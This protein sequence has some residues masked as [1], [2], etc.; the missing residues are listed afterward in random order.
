MACDR[1]LVRTQGT[2]GAA[3]PVMIGPGGAGGIEDPTM[4]EK[5]TSAVRSSFRAW[6]ESHGRPPALAEAMVDDEVGVK[7]VTWD[8]VKRLLTQNEY[9]DAL[10]DGAE[11]SDVRTVVERG[12]LATF[13]GT[14]AVEFGLADAIADTL[15]EVLED[16]RAGGTTLLER[17]RSEELSALLHSLRF[18]LL[19]GGLV[20]AYL[21]LKMPGFGIPGILSITCFA[22]FLFGQYTVGL[23]D[24][25]HIVMVGAGLALLAVE[26]FLAPGTL[27]FGIAGALL[28]VSGVVLTI[29]G[30]TW[31]LDYA[32]DRRIAFDAI[33]ALALWSTAAVFI[34]W[35]LARM[36]PYTPGVSWMVLKPSGGPAT[37]EGVAETRT[38][39][40]KHAMI[41]A[42]G[43]AIT[44]L[45]PVGRI[46]LD[47]EPGEDFEARTL[48]TAL[49]SGARVRVIE[50]QSGRL[51]VEREVKA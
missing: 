40:E 32:L 49:D 16:M 17:A 50:V 3:A 35:G 48:G 37:G 26:I 33:F 34:A 46:T 38:L 10:A 6:A 43:Q 19:L 13:S 47:R 31:D 8:G 25:P 14:Q 18:L 20:G 42:V 11:M 22:V 30:S 44:D 12:K 41:G 28:L 15:E 23:A 5:V 45:R 21:E 2:I 51:V 7:E 36:I 24:V 27:W 4:K 39:D 9:D 1:V 29:G